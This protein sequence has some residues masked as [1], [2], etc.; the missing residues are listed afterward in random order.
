ME[1]VC[2]NGRT[3]LFDAE[4]LALVNERAWSVGKD[5][6]V[7]GTIEGQTIKL[8]RLLLNA[9][10]D[11]VVDHINGVPSDCRKQNLRI[12]SQHQNTMNC[13]IPKNSKT[14]FKGVCFDKRRG[15]YM[16]HIHPGRKTKF[17]GYYESPIEA[18]LAYDKAA[19]F[20]FGSFAKLNFMKEENNES[21]ILAVG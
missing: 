7:H 3:F 4:D 16:A 11:M 8:H 17:L 20:Y 21:Q 15:K 9:P 13:S 2:K 10:S 5:G 12:G 19:S 18:A 14:G 6:Y 1:Y